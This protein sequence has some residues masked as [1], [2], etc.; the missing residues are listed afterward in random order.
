ML[1]VRNKMREFAADDRGMV[2]IMVSIMLPVLIGFTLLVIDMSRAHNLHNDLQKGADAIAIAAAAE[3]NGRPDAWLRAERA[4]R[5]IVAN[6]SRFADWANLAD[7]D[8]GNVEN[9]TT[10]CRTGG[11]F[12]WCFLA[13]LP[14]SDATAI[15]S[16]NYAATPQATRFIRVQV[17]EPSTA[18]VFTFRAI[19][20]ASFLGGTNSFNFGAVAVAG[21]TSSVC[22]FTPVFICN[23]YE[24]PS[25]AGGYTLEQAVASTALRRRQI[26]LRKVGQGA[27]AGPGNFG[28]LEPP[29]GV[30]NG[31]QA[32][33]Q[34][35]ATSEPLGCYAADGVT[36]KTGQNAGP[37]Q[38][39]FNVRFGIRPNGNHFS[40]AEYGPAANVRK[41]AV[42]SS[43]GNGNGNG[44]SCPSYGDLTFNGAGNMG[45]PRDA[46]WPYMNGR[47]GA[48][49]YPLLGAGGYWET[50][51]GS[52]SY[53]SSWD[54]TT[55]TR[56]QVYRYEIE[57]GL[58]S[59]A[60]AGGETGTPPSSCGAP[61]TAIDRR[62]LYG[63]ILNCQALEAAGNALNGHSENLP[64]EVFASFFLTEP[65][66]S[67]S[68]DA[69]VM[70]ELVDITG[71]G[72]L[73]TLDNFLRDEA[74][75]YR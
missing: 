23:P 44:N 55:P 65:V 48:G 56:Y 41:G 69:S 72:G 75:L 51:F 18:G 13:T 64:V 61:V 46:T 62:I 43:N 74:Q 38:D 40:S 7:L 8:N 29:A 20:P 63:A 42:S 22:D 25:A 66:A 58:V 73:G 57:N 70:V 27:A 54:T 35:I 12:S 39:A 59:Q 32:L 67:P 11:D 9:G 31:A 21:F 50:N 16:A 30:G 71:R 5:Y 36:T 45:L 14:A 2:M 3:L 26:E 37:V 49:D 47:M 24:D 1:C 10:Q 53:P 4:L 52:A 28:F 33:A 6:D 60:S 17:N 34:T 68:E 15:T 19:F